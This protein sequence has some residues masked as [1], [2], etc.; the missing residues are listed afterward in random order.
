[1]KDAKEMNKDELIQAILE[2]NKGAKKESFSSFSEE[3]LREYLK[4]LREL[5]ITI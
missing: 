4:H 3:E 2:I 5:D 1:M